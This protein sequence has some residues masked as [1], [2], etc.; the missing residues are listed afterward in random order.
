M[1]YVRHFGMIAPQSLFLYFQ[2]A[3]A[4]GFGLRVRFWR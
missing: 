2:R 1:E 4:E 3:Q